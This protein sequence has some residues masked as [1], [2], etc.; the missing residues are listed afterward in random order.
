MKR[1]AQRL[2]QPTAMALLCAVALYG[3]EGPWE[4]LGLQGYDI[5]A[6]EISPSGV[7]LA[8]TAFEPFNMIF[9][10]TDHGSS[11]ATATD[12]P[13]AEIW[14]MTFDPSDESIVYAALNGAGVWKSLDGG[15]SWVW[16]N[17][18]GQI[19]EVAVSA[20]HP[21]VLYVASQTGGVY[22]TIDAG[23]T[24]TLQDL[25]TVD[26]ATAVAVHPTNPDIAL[27]GTPFW[28]VFKTS[29]G[30]ASWSP[31]NT[32]F[33][34]TPDIRS[35]LFDTHDPTIVYAGEFWNGVFKSLDGGDTWFKPDPAFFATAASIEALDRDLYVM[36]V[37]EAMGHP[38]FRSP[39]GGLSWEPLPRQAEIPEN[40]WPRSL[41]V[42]SGAIL[43]GTTPDQN[44]GG[45]FSWELPCAD[46]GPYLVD[47][48]TKLLLH[49]DTSFVGAQ[50]EVP[51]NEAGT[52]EAGRFADG[53]DA[54]GFFPDWLTYS[55][56]DN[57]EA[58]EGTIE[59]WI[60]PNW[61]GND[62][63]DHDFFAVHSGAGNLNSL[64]LKKD[65]ANNFRYMTWDGTAT[66]SGLFTSIAD[67]ATG[68]WHHLAVTWNSGFI[69]LYI[70]GVI[71][72]SDYAAFPASFETISLSGH[73]GEPFDAWSPDAVV[74]E[75][76]ISSVARCY[77]FPPD[78]DGDSVPDDIDNCPYTPN[79]AQVDTDG[80]TWG[81]LCDECPA[82]PEQTCIS[83]GSTAEEIPAD[84]GGALETPD[85]AVTLDIEPGDLAEDS[86]LSITQ[87]DSPAPIADLVLDDGNG[88]GQPLATYVFEPDG[89]Q[90]N[91]TVTLT[92]IA[93]VSDLNRG[94]RRQLDLYL[95]VDTDADGVEDSFESL[96]ALCSVLEEPAA[97]FTATCTAELAHLSTYSLIAPLDSDGDEVPDRF[98]ILVDACPATT[99][100][101]G[102]PT[103]FLRIN[104]FALIDA[105]TVFDTTESPGGRRSFSYSLDDTAGCSCEQIID[106]LQLG[107]GQR[108]FGCSNSAMQQW[109]GGVAE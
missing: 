57:I 34:F 47:S 19:W 42:E 6:L 59:F 83:G 68:E 33:G 98:G 62:G 25:G 30:G 95:Y 88:S 49:F 64:L 40:F 23:E 79:P 50:G 48:S 52:F 44:P 9:R 84:Q 37:F 99:I 38:A 12:L 72:A 3:A 56:T 16:S 29:D 22:K 70:D 89:L 77:D 73:P 51:T 21:T 78:E 31:V 61:D 69:A 20:S 39:D 11:W 104:R 71:R 45:I 103:E 10:S 66:E 54:S 36:D 18:N 26:N 7:I 85:G 91:G 65:G 96:G 43:L 1:L 90:F 28:G 102:V 107:V 41:A 67:W 108:R 24:W 80:D 101:E 106:A 76:R 100:P 81:D 46:G 2:V 75:V 15:V 17:L 86:T 82:D 32:G 4:P 94:Q 8:G 97:I 14:G 74:D 109:I 92:I 58:G 63:L 87:T 53:I 13:G 27:A 5:W 105:D 93:D 60:K 35:L 55:A